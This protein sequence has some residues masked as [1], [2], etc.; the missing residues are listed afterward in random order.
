MIHKAWCCIE[1][2]PYYFLGSSIKFQ[3]HTAKNRRF[4]SN[5][6]K[7]TRPVAAIKS[8][9]FA[10]FCQQSNYNKTKQYVTEGV[11]LEKY[12]SNPTWEG[13]TVIV[14]MVVLLFQTTAAL[15]RIVVVLIN[16]NSSYINIYKWYQ[17]LRQQSNPDCFDAGCLFNTS[18][19]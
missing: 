6:S 5:L 9:R 19:N 14:R 1:D 8:L 18:Q 3:G 17:R 2:V 4:E 12:L 16:T 7:I 10:L 11:I 13:L 15:N